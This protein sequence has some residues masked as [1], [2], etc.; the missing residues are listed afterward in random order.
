MIGELDVDVPDLPELDRLAELVGVAEEVRPVVTLAVVADEHHLDAALLVL[1]LSPRGEPLGALLGA[2]GFFTRIWQQVGRTVSVRR[3]M[4]LLG[5]AG[6][7]VPT[8]LGDLP[9]TCLLR[10]P[11]DVVI[12][13]HAP[14]GDERGVILRRELDA[15]L[16]VGRE[17]RLV[18][19]LGNGTAADT[20]SDR[21][22]SSIAATHEDLHDTQL[23]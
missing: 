9:V 1:L 13:K 5:G 16:D 4:A 22:L 7:R 3:H 12:T 14:T 10:G 17:R 19:L 2:Q 8:G 6:H 11:G 20:Q 23:L 18:E 21:P 15:P